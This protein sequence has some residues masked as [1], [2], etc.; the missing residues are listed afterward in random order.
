MGYSA[1]P[2]KNKA[3]AKYTQGYYRPINR[4]KYTGNVDAIVY[5]SSWE[6]KFMQYMDTDASITKWN[7][8]GIT[9][10]YRDA[11]GHSHRYYPDFY[12]EKQNLSNP[13]K[14]D[15]VVVE[16]KP[17]C[18]TQMPVKPKNESVKSLTNYEYSVKTYIKNRLKWATASDWCE[19]RGLRFIIVTEKHLKKANIL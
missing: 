9:I 12:Y 5:R 10:V 8:E 17:Y 13:E 7:S 4:D 18:E 15:K 19:K 2:N 16:V 1:R 11:E 3:A 6:L 14:V